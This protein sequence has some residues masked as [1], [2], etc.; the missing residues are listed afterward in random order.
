MKKFLLAFL[1]VLLSLGTIHAQVAIAPV[2]YAQ[3]FCNVVANPDGSVLPCSGGQLFT[4]V[5]GTTTPLATY[6][7]STGMVLNSN[8][9]ILD[10]EGRASI[11]VT[12]SSYKYVLK[13]SDGNLQWSQDN[14]INGGIAAGNNNF[15]GNNTFSGT[16][17]FTGTTNINSGGNLAGSFSGNPNFTG[18]PTFSGGLSLTSN[19]NALTITSESVNPAASGFIRMASNDQQCWQNTSLMNTYCWAFSDPNIMTWPQVL[20]TLELRSLSAGAATSGVVGLANADTINWEN[21]A[22]SGVDSLGVNSLDQLELNGTAIGGFAPTMATSAL[23]QEDFIDGGVASSPGTGTPWSAQGS[24]TGQGILIASAP[25]HLGVIS[26]STGTTSSSFVDLL[27]GNPSLVSLGT[28]S[29]WSFRWIFQLSSTTSEQAV[30]GV[31]DNTGSIVAPNNGIYVRYD[32]TLGDT[33]FTF[34]TSKTGAKTAVPS[35]IPADTNWHDVLVSSVVVGQII[36]TIDGGTPVTIATN[37]P[38][39]Y[40]FASCYIGNTTTADKDLNVDFFGIGINGLN[41]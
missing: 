16:N 38:N 29:P 27:N 5:A 8:P 2:P 14:V 22:S 25:P 34:V 13:D 21:A 9:I 6:T 23:Y 12:T 18:S 36:F 3:F 19:L 31:S 15:T 26:L 32:T 7:D 41:R 28:I 11:W 30:C 4:Y 33:N 17:T 1:F 20:Q 37:I 10:A 39:A 24:G 35:T 40:A